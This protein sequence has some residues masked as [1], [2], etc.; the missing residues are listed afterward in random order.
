MSETE[1]SSACAP[2]LE[3]V[4]FIGLQASGKTSFFRARLDRTHVQVSKDQ[5]RHAKKPNARQERLIVA[6]LQE[7][8]SVVVDNTNVTIEDRLSV[9]EIARRFGARVVGYYFES[10]VSECR[11][12]NRVREGKSRV[13]DVALY[14]MVKQLVR[15]SYAEGFDEL[16][17]VRIQG[18][19]DFE[20]LKWIDEAVE[21][22]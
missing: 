10:R 16:F 8:R 3:V 6:A 18:G 1:K 7:G 14:S 22:G 17:Y 5:F 15:P 11:E 12:R 13:P 4:I 19:F 9:I 2:K 20:V 21:N